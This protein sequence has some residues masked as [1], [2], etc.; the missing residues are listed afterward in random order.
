MINPTPQYL[1]RVHQWLVEERAAGKPPR[2][3]NAVHGINRFYLENQIDD[4]DAAREPLIEITTSGAYIIRFIHNNPP[5]NSDKT[6]VLSRP[7]IK[8]AWDSLVGRG[9]I[10]YDKIRHGFALTRLGYIALYQI[11]RKGEI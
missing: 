6:G 1:K 4:E 3:T 9:L 10:D 11:S 7:E 8:L 5:F 2:T